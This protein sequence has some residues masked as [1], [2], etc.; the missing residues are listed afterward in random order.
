[1]TSLAETDD[2]YWTR[3]QVAKLLKVSERHVTNLIERAG[4]PYVD[5]GGVTRF[6][7]SELRRWLAER[8]HRKDVA[9]PE[10][11]R[12]A[13]TTKRAPRNSKPCNLDLR[14]RPAT[15]Q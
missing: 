9:E 7:H 13:R 8:T 12:A 4:L 5:L 11:R 15:I 3:A 6:P 2:E 1:M 14:P 10:I